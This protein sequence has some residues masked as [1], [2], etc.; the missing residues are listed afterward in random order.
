MKSILKK[1][2]ILSLCLLMLFSTVTPTTALA[3]SKCSHKT[4][5]WVTTTDPGCYNT[6]I[7]ELRCAKCGKYLNK[8]KKL[9]KT[10]HKFKTFCTWKPSCTEC[11]YAT[12][13]CN[14]CGDGRTIKVGKALGHSWS[15]WKKNPFTGK[16]TRHCTRS[17]CDAK[18]TK[19]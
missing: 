5:E 18:E 6:G 8:E 4:K 13:L 2:S 16:Y 19:K 14:I 15:K 12:Q 1:L 10:K 9:P 17:K 7:A 3:K 11:G